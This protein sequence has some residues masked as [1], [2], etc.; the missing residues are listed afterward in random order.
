M[1]CSEKTKTFFR[2]VN[3]FYA[4]AMV[5]CVF[6]VH[7]FTGYIT[8]LCVRWLLSGPKDLTHKSL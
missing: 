8:L 3:E 6:L 5:F 1:N 4:F 2:M 7:Y